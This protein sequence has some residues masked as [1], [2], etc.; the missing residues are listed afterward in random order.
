MK[1]LY[2]KNCEIC[3]HPFEY[4]KYPSTEREYPTRTCSR[5]C[6]DILCSKSLRGRFIPNKYNIKD[7]TKRKISLCKYCGKEINDQQSV[8]RTFCGIPCKGFWQSENSK[9]ENNPNWKPLDQKKPFRSV[10]KKL[11][12]DTIRERKK[13]EICASTINLQI[14]HKNR[15]RGDNSPNNILLLCQLCHA[16]THKKEGDEEIARLILVHPQSKMK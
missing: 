10:N 11:R 6:R 13:C 9:G 7:E 12:K 1:T 14:H 8:K 3:N 4:Y 16:D 15:N 2:K 5:K